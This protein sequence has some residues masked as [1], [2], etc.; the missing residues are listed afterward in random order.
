M[1]NL[2]ALWIIVCAS[3]VFFMQA[4]FICYE[5]GFVQ[6]KNMVSVAIEN[7]IAFVIATLVFWG[8]GFGLMFGPTINGVV[9]GGY[10]ML[11]GLSNNPNNLHFAYAFFQLMFAGTAVTIFSGSMSE[12]TKLNGLVIS[13]LVMA[14]LVYPVFGHW[15]WGGGYLMQN[16]WLQKLGFIDFAGGIVV[17]ATSGWFALAGIIVVGARRGR[18]DEKGVVQ[19]LG[20]SNIPFAALGTF[21]L[22]F[23]WFGFNG[24]SLLHFDDRVALILLNT[25]FAA[26]AGVVGAVIATW[27][28]HRGRSYMEAIFSGS[29]G[30]L[31]S[32]TSASNLLG[33][34]QSILTGFTA[35]IIVIFSSIFLEKLKLDDA[36]GAVPI[37]AFGGAAGSLLLAFLVS[38]EHLAA[39]SRAAQFAVQFLGITVNF[40]WSFGI[41]FVLFTLLHKLFGLR[42]T[43][44]EEAKGLN[45]V[46]FND[47]YSWADY[48]KTAHY[49]NESLSLN[50]QIGQQNEELKRQ[51]HLL[52]ATQEQERSKLGRDLH[53]GLGQALATLKLQLGILRES[54]KHDKNNSQAENTVTQTLNLVDK[55]IGEMR[56][57]I[58]NLRPAT[59]RE[60]GLQATILHTLTAI[61]QSTGIKV[62][63]IL[64]SNLPAWNEEVEF[65][66][67]RIIQEVLANILKHAEADHIELQFTQNKADTFTIILTD[68]GK[69][70]SPEEASAGI[71]LTSIR[72]RAAMIG[73]GLVIRSIPEQGT[74]ILLEVPLEKN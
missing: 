52:L 15:A 22:W 44:E 12:R 60:N 55:A 41:G 26:A 16:T 50:K 19:K 61:Q 59:L 4:G 33:P 38:P 1:L 36:V 72:E 69:G 5:V 46:E 21:I 56:S 64:N 17:H 66:I 30:G 14:G 23:S 10:W 34:S 18:F 43:A 35:G 2:D 39:G 8:W 73:G 51:A 20:R 28:A 47:I 13:A 58:H 6:A 68:N 67:Y 29:L 31:V 70:F 40:L 54:M 3:F 74:A 53:D 63:T 27:A 49:E 42:V 48:L 24:G 45:I 37:H 32:I 57:V 25:N 71:G 7:I 11:T 62:I 9:G 65:N